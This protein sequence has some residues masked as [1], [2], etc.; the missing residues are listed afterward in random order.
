MRASILFSCLV[1]AVP[2]LLRAQEVQLIP[3]DAV[4]LPAAPSTVALTRSALAE[5]SPF[6]AITATDPRL[7]ANAAPCHSGALNDLRGPR[8]E[9]CTAARTC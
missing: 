9:P 8:L 1:L 6:G 4:E 7:G 3:R 5:S 2:A